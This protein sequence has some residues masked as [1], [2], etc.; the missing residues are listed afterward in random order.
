MSEGVGARAPAGTKFRVERVRFDERALEAS[1]L[2]RE[3]RLSN[4]PVVYTLEDRK[5]VY[6]GET[7]NA[8]S[9][10]QSH[11]SS[12]SKQHLRNGRIVIGDEFNKSVCLDLESWLI[13]LFAGDAKYEV[14]NSNRGQ[15]DHDYFG[16]E[17]YRKSFEEIFEKLREQ[18]LFERSLPEIENRD[19]FKLSPFKALTPDQA[20][21][22]DEIVASLSQ[23]IA[24]GAPTI[25][26]V[27][28][29]PGTGKTVIAIYLMKLLRDIGRADPED[30]LD[31]D[32]RFAE[33]FDTRHVGRFTGLRIGLVV[34]QQSL[35]LSIQRV[36]DKTPGLERSMVLSPFQVGGTKGSYDVLIVDETHRLNQRAAQ[37]S[38]P[39]NAQ[40]AEITTNLFGSDDLSKTQLDWIHEKSTHQI[41]FVDTLQTVR[42]A[43]LPSDVLNSVADEARR[44]KRFHRLRTQHRIK[45]PGEG[46]VKHIREVLAGLA[47]EPKPDRFSPYDLRFYDNPE[48]MRE[49]ILRL[50]QSEGLARMLAGYA[51]KW[52]SKNDPDARDIE[53][54][55]LSM[56]WNGAVKDWVAS[57]GSVD[58]V[59]SIHTIQG[60]DLNYA[61]VLVGPDLGYDPE[62]ERV[63]FRRDNYFDRQGMRN[64]N[65][66]GIKYS[67]DDVLAYVRNIY[68]VLMTRGILG[69]FVHVTDPALREYLRPYFTAG[70]KRWLPNSPTKGSS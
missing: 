12:A 2:L 46:Y 4:W 58:E 6:V 53:I 54:D 22:V 34:P 66:L 60:Y 8:L 16:R 52:R 50:D 30:P 42:P 3:E 69:T 15:T 25:S 48:A 1:A 36:F 65:Q 24:T 39:Q 18:G 14:L 45:D 7:G 21:A 68:A 41:L 59:G 5:S 26:L 17:E 20:D 57:A 29:E 33:F 13:N 67:D 55:D 61:G 43:D 23:A 37:S 70:Q 35:R 51:W 63:V 32:A 27:E 19:L 40:F 62:T 49:E 47:P 38:G 10:L 11:L 44:K 31:E 9:R 64:N 28:G 56:R